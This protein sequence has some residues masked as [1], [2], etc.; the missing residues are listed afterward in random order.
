MGSPVTFEIA[1]AKM[2]ENWPKA[3]RYLEENI[4]PDHECWA[5]VWVGSHFVAGIQTTGRVESEHKNHQGM[6][7]GPL[8]SVSDVFNRLSKRGEQQQD[9]DFVRILQ[10]L[11]H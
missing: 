11:P 8:S 3:V 2:L 6:G 9:A 1:W 4:Y 10:V 5:W 7:L